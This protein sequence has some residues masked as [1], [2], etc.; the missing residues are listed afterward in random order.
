MRATS[1][2]A[3]KRTPARTFRATALAAALGSALWV[4]GCGEPRSAKR[5]APVKSPVARV[6][7]NPIALRIVRRHAE[8][9]ALV[10]EQR[11]ARRPIADELARRGDATGV[12]FAYPTEDNR[13]VHVDA[14]P[15]RRVTVVAFLGSDGTIDSVHEL[16]A[17]ELVALSDGPIRFAL[18]VTDAAA[19][20][21]GLV[22]G[23]RVALPSGAADGAEPEYVPITDPPPTAITVGGKTV[24]VEVAWQAETRARGLMYRSYIPDNAGMLFVFRDARQQNF[25]MRNTRASLDIAYIDENNRIRNVLTMRA[26]DLDSSGQYRSEG[27]VIMALETRAGWFRENGVKRGATVVL[28]EAISALREK[29][30]P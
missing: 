11:A 4:T 21:L 13:S 18:F 30:A 28:P 25:W 29:A 10:P 1:N 20:R 7:D 22:A 16:A 26:H 6:G 3:A 23:G 9:T 5:D 27:P 12:L 24:T 17:K 19:K 8:R 15:T 14:D 2:D